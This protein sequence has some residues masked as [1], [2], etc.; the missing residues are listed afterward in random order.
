MDI[1]IED[2]RLVGEKDQ[3]YRQV[4]L[5]G[6]EDPCEIMPWLPRP[7]PCKITVSDHVIGD[8]ARNE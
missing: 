3:L 4:D 6:W 2:A 1:T 5:P 7:V 8:D